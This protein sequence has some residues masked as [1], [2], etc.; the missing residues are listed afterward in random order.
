M[1]DKK[2]NESRRKLL[3]SIAAGSGAVVAGKSLP[4]SWSKPVVDAVLL[5]AHA[6]TTGV[7]AIY[8]Y[9][10]SRQNENSRGC[11]QISGNTAQV[12]LTHGGNFDGGGRKYRFTGTI[13]AD[14]STGTITLAERGAGCTDGQD[15]V[16]GPRTAAIT[17]LTDDSLVLVFQA[18]PDSG[19]GI[20]DDRYIRADNCPTVA[21]AAC[22]TT[23]QP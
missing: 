20:K 21:V 22:T 18:G 5:P 4:E 10:Y 12:N 1:S 23:L 17:F 6:A 9:D 16:S 8:E 11:I 2:S 7:T 15:F 3:K 13:P 14:G 19:D